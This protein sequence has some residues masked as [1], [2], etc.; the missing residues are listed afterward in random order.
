MRPNSVDVA[1]KLFVRCLGPA[2]HGFDFHF[3]IVS[4]GGK[5][6]FVDTL[7]LPFRQDLF[8]IRHNPLWMKKLE[9]FLL[10]FVVEDEFK[11]GMDIGDVF[12][13]LAN[14]FRVECRFGKNL[15]IGSEEN[16]RPTTAKRSDL[17]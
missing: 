11:S 5:D 1:A 12:Q 15:F 14:D 10:E 13:M 17:L 16:C 7:L 8:E 9:L 2:Q 6:L 3:A 4:R